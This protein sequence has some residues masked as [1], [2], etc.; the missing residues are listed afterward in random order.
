MVDENRIAVF[1]AEFDYQIRE[2]DRIYEIIQ[3]RMPLDAK[4]PMPD[5]LVESIGYWLHNLYCAYED[6]FKIVCSFWENNISSASGYHASLLKRM[7]LAIEG[8]RPALLSEESFRILDQ[9]RGFRHVF[10]HA[11]SH[12]LDEERVMILCNRIKSSNPIIKKDLACFRQAA[13]SIT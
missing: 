1:L 7:V 12:G 4:N 10:R 8:I 3:T 5:E 11:Y 2:I 6:L 9:L 13:V